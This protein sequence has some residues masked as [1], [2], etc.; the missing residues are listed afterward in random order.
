[1]VHA[2]G[3]RFHQNAIDALHA[4][5]ETGPNL[6]R[7]QFL[8]VAG[9]SAGSGLELLDPWLRSLLHRVLIEPGLRRPDW[10]G[11]ISRFLDVL[12]VRDGTVFC[13]V[14]SAFAGIALPNAGFELDDGIVR[15]ALDSDF[16]VPVGETAPVGIVFE[17]RTQ[18][19]ASAGPVG[20]SFPD[21]L[22]ARIETAHQ[23]RLTRFLLAVALTTAA[24]VQDQL[25]MK[26]ID[27]G[28]GGSGRLPEEV[29]P[30]VSSHQYLLDESAIDRICDC[31]LSLAGKNLGRLGVAT[32][33]F[34][35]ARTE[36][37]RPAD[38]IIDYAIALES[39]TSERY[40]DKQ[41]KELARLLAN[42]VSERK[43]IESE[44]KRFRAAREAIVHDGV[45]PPDVGGVAEMGRG[46]VKR[47][48]WARSQ[49]A[50]L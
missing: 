40:A 30:I 45:I 11:E 6:G 36:R 42:D 15:P 27:F 39:M 24:P 35:V 20:L 8:H 7:D 28:G 33:R 12:R 10:E 14:K 22:V 18:L 4:D 17:Y 5:P 9:V 2:G 16:H 19:P 3:S 48:L 23:T 31:Y 50:G 38:Q 37:V 1:M 46:L 26:A 34:L 47:S 32:R 41:G 49:A 44:H 43:V 29:G 21:E 13:A 25:V